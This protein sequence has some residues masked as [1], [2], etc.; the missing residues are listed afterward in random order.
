MC[1]LGGTS[2]KS[3]D[4]KCH[5]SGTQLHAPTRMEAL[6]IT[7][8]VPWWSLSGSIDASTLDP[9]PTTAV[10]TGRKKQRRKKASTPTAGVKAGREHQ[11][12]MPTVRASMCE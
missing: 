4:P 5:P 7:V 2:S 12:E 9:E 3:L 8:S 10:K 1:P 6:T 11:Q